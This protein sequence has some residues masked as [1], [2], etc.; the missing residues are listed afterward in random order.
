[1]VRLISAFFAALYLTPLL[2]GAAQAQVVVYYDDTRSFYTPAYFGYVTSLGPVPTVVHNSPFAPA[3][4]AARIPM[5]GFVGRGSFVAAASGTD[6]LAYDRLVLAFNT[7]AGTS[8]PALC[9][10]PQVAGGAGGTRTELV[11][12]LCRGTYPASY[13]VL[14]GPAARSPDDL[15]AL[16]AQMTTVVMPPR[17]TDGG[18]SPSG[19]NIC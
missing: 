12:A 11:A 1:M 19:G 14:S 15:R 8:A 5:P 10:Q 17:R 2:V 13:A 4:V 16:L 6:I 3:D 7:G 18:C 9:G